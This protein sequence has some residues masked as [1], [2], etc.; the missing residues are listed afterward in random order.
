MR[1]LLGT[2]LITVVLTVCKQERT[3]KEELGSS[4]EKIEVNDTEGTISLAWEK[5]TIAFSFKIIQ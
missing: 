2:I 3:M 1:T 4:E 5:V